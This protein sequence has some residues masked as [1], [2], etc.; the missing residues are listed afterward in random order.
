LFDIASL[1]ERREDPSEAD[2]DHFL[3]LAVHHFSVLSHYFSEHGGG[4]SLSFLNI[5]LLL[6]FFSLGAAFVTLDFILEEEHL[7]IRS[8]NFQS[9]KMREH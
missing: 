4:Y 6:F 1:Q 3:S 7:L 2:D 5:S 9:Q 8:S